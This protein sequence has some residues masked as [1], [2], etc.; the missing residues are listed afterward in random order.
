MG[1]V[2]LL[3]GCVS[4][5]SNEYVTASVYGVN[6][7][8]DYVPDFSILT[9]SGEQT[10]MGGS[11]VQEFS[12]GG[13]SGLMCCAPIP[14]P[15]RS[16]IVSWHIGDRKEGEANWK[17]FRKT[18]V[19]RGEAS[20]DPDKMNSLVVRFFPGYEV[21]AELMCESTGPDAG[22]SPRLDQLFYGRRVMRR[23]GG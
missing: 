21:E 4:T 15:G 10:G 2:G 14:K 12:K 11:R 3:Y 7:S 23:M 1:T 8:E 16:L 18:V 6:Y 17:S 13:L 20:N 9:E 5:K 19:V 22:P